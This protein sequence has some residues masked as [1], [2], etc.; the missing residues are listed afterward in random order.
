VYER[1]TEPL[2]DYY[3]NR[4]LLCDVD[5]AQSSDAIL[6]EIMAILSG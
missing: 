5:G 4:E 1:S 6:S 3:K 2:I